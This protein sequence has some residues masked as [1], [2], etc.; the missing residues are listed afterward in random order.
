[1]LA[2]MPTYVNYIGYIKGRDINQGKVDVIVTDGFT[3]NAVLKTM[4]GFASFMLGNLREL[5]TANWRTRLSYLLVRRQLTAMRERFDP[6]EYG[7]APLLGLSGVAIIAHGSSNPH[8]I[9]NA[10]RT[11]ANEAL[12]HRVNA[13][14]LE[15]VTKTQQATPTKPAASKEM[16]G[17]CSPRCASTWRA[18]PK[19][20]NTKRANPAMPFMRCRRVQPRR[21]RTS[22][23]RA[24]IPAYRLRKR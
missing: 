18:I 3:G 8:A 9:R 23:R 21:N 10:I 24:S 11:A 19:I 16:H 6:H 5:F 17:R 2:Q 20:K 22:R 12:V 15:I 13:E 14:I 7:G 4:E 1:M